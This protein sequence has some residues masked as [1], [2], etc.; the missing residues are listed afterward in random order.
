MMAEQCG[1]VPTGGEI[2]WLVSLYRK[3]LPEEEIRVFHGLKIEVEKLTAPDMRGRIVQHR[4]HDTLDMK[5]HWAQL[6]DPEGYTPREIS[7]RD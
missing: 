7:T 4:I 1:I 2:K 3:S 5:E 6:Q